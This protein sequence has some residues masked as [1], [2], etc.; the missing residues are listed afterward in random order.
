MKSIK[1]VLVGALA[2]STAFSLAACAEKEET[3]KQVGEAPVIHG[4]EDKDIL[5]GE[6]FVAFAGV[7]VTDKEDGE[8]SLTEVKLTGSVQN[9]V[10]GQYD[11]VYSVT[12]SHGNTTTEDRTITVLENDTT[13]PSITGAA[14]VTL[15]LGDDFDVLAGV[16]ALD[17]IDGDI[18]SDIV[19]A[20]TVNV[21]AEGEYKVTYNVTDKSGNAATQVTRTIT[22]A[23]NV[24]YGAKQ[25][26]DNFEGNTLTT[27][28]SSVLDTESM[29][30]GMI[31]INFT[32]TVLED[33]KL[34]I[35]L[36]GAT[37]IGEI[38]LT[39]DENNYS[40]YL[41]HEATLTN[42]TVTL[43]LEEVTE[44]PIISNVTLEYGYKYKIPPTIV[45]ASTYAGLVPFGLTEDDAKKFIL[46]GVTATDDRDSS[47]DVT[48]RLD[49]DFGD[50]N[51]TTATGAVEVFITTYDNDGCEAREAVTI[52]IAEQTDNYLQDGDFSKSETLGEIDN[53]SANNATDTVWIEDGELVHNSPKLPGWASDTAP[54][55]IIANEGDDKYFTA[56]NY[57][58]LQF[59]IT[60]DIARTGEVRF[61]LSTD[62]ANGWFDDFAHVGGSKRFDTKDGG[63]Y[64]T[65]SYLFYMDSE[66]S[67]AGYTDIKLE[68]QLGCF[69]WDNNK[70]ANNTSRIDNVVISKVTFPDTQ[71]PVFSG[72][73]DEVVIQDSDWNPIIG[74]EAYDA[75]EGDVTDSIEV[76]ETTYDLS[77]PGT[78]QVKYT[79]TDSLGNKTV[80]YRTIT[81]L[82][83]ELPTMTGLRNQRVEMKNG[84]DFLE[85]VTVTDFDDNY[86][87][88]ENAGLVVTVNGVVI[89]I[90]TYQFT[91][92]GIYVVQYTATGSTGLK[93]TT[94]IEIDVYVVTEVTVDFNDYADEEALKEQWF[95]KEG[96]DYTL[97]GTDSKYVNLV[98]GTEKTEI[99][100][101][102]G[103]FNTTLEDESVK[104][105][106]QNNTTLEITYKSNTDLF[107][108][109]IACGNGSDDLNDW[110][111]YSVTKS[112]EEWTTVTIN[113]ADVL[114]DKPYTEIQQVM[115]VIPTGNDQYAPSN[116][117][118]GNYVQ[119][120]SIT[121]K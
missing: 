71:G 39:E 113:L 90:S 56:N 3:N 78:Y 40:V 114:G 55:L 100:G 15:E 48:Y 94:E 25:S 1:R 61:G 45:F 74:V 64:A 120:K 60:S 21:W 36:D 95:G 22:V 84:F 54:Q 8:I 7:S 27:E 69:W 34:T 83:K 46:D 16:Q 81:V 9:N 72:L 2:A 116:N 52:A 80:A 68:I 112:N 108:I 11:L 106:W 24:D 13:A 29:S 14:N 17:N 73:T 6:T 99:Y 47:A 31:R 121:L 109:T 103:L 97:A 107:Q 28:V 51:I 35:E 62:E 115:I 66:V 98:L 32:A 70:E 58:L 104:N 76:D 101:Y 86:N 57:Y 53:W 38:L 89:D 4:V 67:T 23:D 19:T 42:K 87:I 75:V 91:K 12:D 30:F 117:V 82:D 102:A 105:N 65:I 96:V 10:V 37:S 111:G 26:I 20:G 18:S 92:E 41:R 118:T 44:T 59:E 79:A 77:K 88:I 93:L 63:E 85:G 5:K 110:K 49:V 50:V 33:T 43:T 119:V